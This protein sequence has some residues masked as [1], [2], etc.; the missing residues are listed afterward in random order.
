MSKMKAIQKEIRQITND[1]KQKYKLQIEVKMRGNNLKHAWQG[2]YT[3]I[4]KEEKKIHINTNG[5]D[6]AFAN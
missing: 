3:M 1:C 5:D 6:Q 2:M 4:G